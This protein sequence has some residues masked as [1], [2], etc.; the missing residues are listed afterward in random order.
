MDD[1]NTVPQTMSF[2]L[3]GLGAVAVFT[4]GYIA[5]IVARYRNLRADERLI[6]EL[7]EDE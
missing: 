5:T 6:R 4:L 1:A 2:L 3:L 7:A